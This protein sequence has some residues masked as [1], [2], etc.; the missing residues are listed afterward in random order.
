VHV[1]GKLIHENMEDEVCVFP[2]RIRR[3]GK[4]QICDDIIKQYLQY[5]QCRASHIVRNVVVRD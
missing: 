1:L 5:Q 2:E 4:Q 3:G